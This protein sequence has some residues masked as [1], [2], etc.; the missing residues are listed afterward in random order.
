MH[1][2]A[3]RCAPLLFYSQE[4]IRF[5]AGGVLL[6]PPIVKEKPHPE[7]ADRTNNLHIPVSY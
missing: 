2:A 3:C 4:K 1:A 6:H 7:I 5:K